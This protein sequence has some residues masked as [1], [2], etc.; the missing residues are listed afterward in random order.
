MK[1]LH[2]NLMKQSQTIA[3]EHE[4][5]P[6]QPVG[7]LH[8]HFRHWMFFRPGRSLVRSDRV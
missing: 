7:Y 3:S 4:A 8:P 1:F 5:Q 2:R 6:H